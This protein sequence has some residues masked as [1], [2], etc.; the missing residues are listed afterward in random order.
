M[1]SNC[2]I[3]VS[4]K[5]RTLMNYEYE[6]GSLVSKRDSYGYGNG[7]KYNELIVLL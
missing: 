3:I 5:K 4:C 7:H 2:N 1:S 6:L